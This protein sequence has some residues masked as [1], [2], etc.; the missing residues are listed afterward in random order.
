[1]PMYIMGCYLAEADEDLCVEI[2]AVAG[3]SGMSGLDKSDE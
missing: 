2:V 3:E 1:M